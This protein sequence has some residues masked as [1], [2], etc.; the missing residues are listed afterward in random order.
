MIAEGIDIGLRGATGSLL[1][2]A[3]I[4][5][6]RDGRSLAARLG[7]ALSL[8]GVLYIVSDA[9]M[10]PARLWGFPVLGGVGTVAMPVFWLFTRAWFDDGFAIGRRDLAVI[11][12]YVAWR[13][14]HLGF[15]IGMGAN[16]ALWFV[17]TFAASLAFAVHAMWIAWRD[18]DADLVEARRRLRLG[19]VLAVGGFLVWTL[20]SE[21]FAFMTGRFSG[22]RTVNAGVLLAVV[23]PLEA[24]LLTLRRSDMFPAA[25]GMAP[26]MAPAPAV[27]ARLAAA[28]DR[29]M[30]HDRIYRSEG[31]TIGAL[32][33][34]LDVPDYRLRQLI[35]G[36][37]GFRNFNEFLNHHR[38]AE[39]KAALADPAQAQ[40]PILTIA[41]DAG[42]GSLAPFNRAFKAAAGTTPRAFR[43]AALGNAVAD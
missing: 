24:V 11:A 13:I 4:V 21:G 2:L 33:A 29:L 36:A 19:F 17:P 34:R 12:A 35:N 37:L 18:R 40:V 31:L 22:W 16:H 25:P 20:L 8:C 39:V 41:M 15:G 7:A 28:L 43:G 1:L 5:F 42:F 30:S 23:L 26:A 9:P 3:A 27:D 38:L 14:A 6:A 10:M 32:A